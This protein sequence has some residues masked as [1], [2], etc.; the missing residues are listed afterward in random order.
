MYQIFPLSAAY[1]RL[2]PVLL[3]KFEHNQPIRKL[4][5]CAGSRHDL[6]PSALRMTASSIT[7]AGISSDPTRGDCGA[8]LPRLLGLSTPGEESSAIGFAGTG[9]GKL[10]IAACTTSN[11]MLSSLELSNPV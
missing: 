10:L 7:M 11:Q 1:I 2:A 9:R 4:G 8:E 3:T 6:F 5:P